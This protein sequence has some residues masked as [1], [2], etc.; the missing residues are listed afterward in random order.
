MLTCATIPVRG[1]ALIA[2]LAMKVGVHPRTF[3]SFQILCCTTL[4]RLLKNAPSR[5]LDASIS[6]KDSRRR[7]ARRS[8]MR[9]PHSPPQLLVHKSAQPCFSGAV[10]TCVEDVWLGY[11]SSPVKQAYRSV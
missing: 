7:R 4:I 11:C 6:G 10:K 1:I 5:R 8:G 3:G 9:Q 2:F